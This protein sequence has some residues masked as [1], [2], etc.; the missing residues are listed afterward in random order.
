MP[1]TAAKPQP[2]PERPAFVGVVTAKT[3]QVI[4]A[5]FDGKVTRVDAQANQRVTPGDKI[6]LLDDTDLK[7]KIA[8]SEA[9]EQS[10]LSEAA[11]AGAMAAKA[12]QTYRSQAMLQRHGIVSGLAVRAARAD[13]GQSG[14]QAQSARRR[15]KAERARREPLLRQLEKAQVTAPIAGVVSRLKARVGAD[16][17]TG[18]PIAQI[19]DPADLKIRFAIPK[20]L[21]NSVK[22]GTRVALHITNAQRTIYASIDH[23][24]DEDAPLEFDT[25]EADIDD[26]KLAPGEIQIGADARIEIADARI[27][28]RTTRTTKT[29]TAGAPR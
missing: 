24:I 19:N 15:A 12:S 16:V 8:A 6:A 29:Q 20:N 22:L 28:T 5:P 3:S 26:S 1:T 27:T 23:F 25:A 17:K 9:N 11:S 2:A 21:R 7:S 4:T 14:A 13:L 10:A 18:E